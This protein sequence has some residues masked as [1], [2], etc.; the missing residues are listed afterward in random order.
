L[1][2]FGMD[3]DDEN[4]EITLCICEDDIGELLKDG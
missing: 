3:D 4:G 2:C 1:V